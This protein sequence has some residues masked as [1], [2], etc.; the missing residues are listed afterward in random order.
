MTKHCVFYWG[1][2]PAE[3]GGNFSLQAGIVPSS[4][5]LRFTLGQ[6]SRINQ[7]NNL[8]LTD[9]QSLSTT[10]MRCRVTRATVLQAGG[11]GR[12]YEVQFVDRRWMWGE[13]CFAVYGEYNTNPDQALYSQTSA[14]ARTY[15]QLASLCLDAM[16]E[17]GYDLTALPDFPGPP[18]MWDAADPAVELQNLCASVGCLVTLSPADRVVIVRDGFGR[19]PSADPR[20]MDFTAS[21]EPPVVPAAVVFEG[22]QTHIQHDLYLH[23]VAEEPDPASPNYKKWVSIYNVSYYA[24]LVAAGGLWSTEDPNRFDGVGIA[25]GAA[26]QLLAKRDVWRRYAVLGPIQLPIPP[27]EL[28]NR[29]NGQRLTATQTNQLNSFFK[30]NS[31]EAW[32]IL[33][34]NQKQNPSSVLGMPSSDAVVAGYRWLGGAANQNTGGFAQISSLP[35]RALDPDV[36]IVPL[37]SQAFNA[38]IVP[39]S[40]YRIDF[41]EGIVYFQDAMYFEDLL[42]FRQPAVIRLRT[43]FLLRDRTSAAPVCAQWWRVPGSPIATDL[44]KVVKRS[45]VWL[46]Y[47]AEGN[48]NSSEFKSAADYFLASELNAYSI[49]TGYSAPYKGFVFDIPVDGV[50]RTVAWDA[51]PESGGM[52]HIDYNMERPEAYLTLTELHARRLATWNAFKAADERAKIARGIKVP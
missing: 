30:I 40:E 1:N 52:T 39:P 5:V 12:F 18:V 8:I 48:D 35:S 31:G 10:F 51:T 36:N 22:G 49:G 46:E 9:R 44:A 42:A 50:V 27:A 7:I 6:Q 29:T 33:P 25:S 43:S 24:D 2:E 20:Q 4:G 41:A 11:G 28:M 38:L 23:P 37:G 47:D 15:R 3:G 21:T 16:G 19:L 34:W 13:R 26:N 17:V 45:D 14:F 32:R